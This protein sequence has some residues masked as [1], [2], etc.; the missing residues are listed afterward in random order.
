MQSKL[1]EH[2]NRVV[3]EMQAKLDT[4]NSQ[5]AS[6]IASTVRKEVDSLGVQLKADIHKQMTDIN[7]KID[8]IQ[9][10]FNTELGSLQKCVGG[11]IE[12]VN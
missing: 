9:N 4:H 3:N 2:A 12:R 7:N 5:L 11:C 8:Q 1:D 10:N 6:S